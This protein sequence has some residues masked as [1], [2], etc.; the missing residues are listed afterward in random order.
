MYPDR[1]V[2]PDLRV[3]RCASCPPSDLLTEGNVPRNRGLP[4]TAESTGFDTRSIKQP[5]SC[6]V[7]LYALNDFGPILFEK[8]PLFLFFSD[9]VPVFC[10]FENTST[11]LTPPCPIVLLASACAFF[12]RWVP[13]LPHH[14]PHLRLSERRLLPLVPRPMTRSLLR[15]PRPTKQRKGVWGSLWPGR[16]Q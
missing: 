1:T 3:L 14:A 2:G 6:H 10:N 7:E 5:L 4:S 15:L 12:R 13:A 11:P 8:A 9:N 16:R